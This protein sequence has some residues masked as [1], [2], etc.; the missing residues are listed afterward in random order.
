[1]TGAQK[2]TSSES[3]QVDARSRNPDKPVTSPYP[4]DSQRTPNPPET[5]GAWDRATPERPWATILQGPTLKQ[6]SAFTRGQRGLGF[7]ASSGI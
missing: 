7:P 3:R 6:G 5:E 2:A 4:A 1:M